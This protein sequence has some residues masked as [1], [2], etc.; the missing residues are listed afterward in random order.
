MIS[1]FYC[2]HE[3][4]V[5][6][7]IISGVNKRNKTIQWGLTDFF[8]IYINTFHWF[9][10]CENK[11]AVIEEAHYFHLLFFFRMFI[12]EIFCAGIIE[13]FLQEALKS[14]E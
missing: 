10:I 14:K 9:F 2:S 7:D 12:D 1:Y 11:P 3:I 8:A 5:V 6:S 4:V 13:V